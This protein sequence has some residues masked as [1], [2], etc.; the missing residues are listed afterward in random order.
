MTTPSLWCD[1]CVARRATNECSACGQAYYCSADCQQ[2]EW[3]QGSHAA[4]CAS[5][6][7]TCSTVDALQMQE[8]LWE[9][10][11]EQ[12]KNKNPVRPIFAVLY[13]PPGS[14]KSTILDKIHA[15]EK[16]YRLRRDETIHVDVDHI[17]A[18][19]PS[20]APE[21]EAA[22]TTALKDGVYAKYRMQAD[23]FSQ[24]LLDTSLFHHY[25]VAW[26]TM[27]RKVD[28][29]T[30]ELDRIR[31]L[32]YHMMAIYPFVSSMELLA[33]R[34][35]ERKTQHGASDIE[36]IWRRSKSNFAKILPFLDQVVIFDNSG[37][38]ERVMLELRR[39]GPRW[40]TVQCP[41]C[42]CDHAEKHSVACA[43]MQKHL[44]ELLG[45]TLV[46]DALKTCF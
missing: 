33:K 5:F 20:Y 14:G 2:E 43:S 26:E 7:G 23:V 12:L 35:A 16:T 37:P 6:I 3:E 40:I 21:L 42:G 24:R 34:V 30:Q 29:T 31:R 45:D 15:E 25:S 17:V 8:G 36:E 10:I 19:F 27:G 39:E 44:R 46:D 4:Q 11:K 9:R 22:C 38:K 1:W 32:G 41:S 13:G 18:A 28:W